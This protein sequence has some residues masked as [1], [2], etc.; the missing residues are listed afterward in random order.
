M[1]RFGFSFTI[2]LFLLLEGTHWRYHFSIL[3][4]LGNESHLG[5]SPC[6]DWVT[7]RHL[8]HVALLLFDEYTLV[9]CHSDIE[10]I[11]QELHHSLVNN[12]RGI[13]ILCNLYLC[14][15]PNT[16]ITP[17]GKPISISKQLL[18]PLSTT[19]CLVKIFDFSFCVFFFMHLHSCVAH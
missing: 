12:V 19:L 2:C 6:L 9:F 17:K 13:L 14:L 1:L 5:C 15:D 8:T 16:L 18:V 11:W 10:F 7:F 3:L 4:S